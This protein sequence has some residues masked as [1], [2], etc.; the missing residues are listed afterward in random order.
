MKHFS[1]FFWF[2]LIVFT[3]NQYLEHF[4]TVPYL[5][6]YL[7]DILCAPIVLGAALGFFQKLL[8]SP[9]YTLPL[10]YVIFFG[11]W[12]ALYFEFI[13]PS[14]D[15]RHHQ[16][17][18]DLLAYALSCYLFFKFGNKPKVKKVVKDIYEGRKDAVKTR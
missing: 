6:A 3:A 8:D 14:Y 4:Y 15:L 13:Y 1:L 18:Y 7:D 10:G 9:E 11:F 17:F 16:D 12:Y 5:H 2:C